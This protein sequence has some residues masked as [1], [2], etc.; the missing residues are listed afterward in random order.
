MTTRGYV[1]LAKEFGGDAEVVIATMGD[2]EAANALADVLRRR[3]FGKPVRR[4]GQHRYERVRV[5]QIN[6]EGAKP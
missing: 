6:S 5:Q 4:G 3:T 1:I 2:W